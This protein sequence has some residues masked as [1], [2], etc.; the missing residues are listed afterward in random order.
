MNVIGT[1]AIS[2]HVPG[3]APWTAAGAAP[4]GG[5]FHNIG[6]IVLALLVLGGLYFG[7]THL[8]RGRHAAPHD[9]QWI[10]RE[11]PPEP[12]SPSSASEAPG[13]AAVAPARRARAAVSVERSAGGWAVE[14]SGLT[15]RFGANVA[16]DGVELRVPRGSAFGCLGPNGAGKTT[17][18]RTLRT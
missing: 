11:P 18:I 14:A 1:Q 5:G 16:V 4:V 12:S 13:G 10:R 6:E 9:D 3:P 15:K 7:V 17:L 2:H 8:R